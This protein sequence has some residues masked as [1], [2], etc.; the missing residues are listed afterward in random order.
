MVGHSTKACT[1]RKGIIIHGKIA[2]STWRYIKDDLPFLVDMLLGNL[3]SINMGI[4]QYV[5]SA[6]VIQNPLIERADEIRTTGSHGHANF[7]YRDASGAQNINITLK[8]KRAVYTARF[9]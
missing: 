2:N 1:E 5:G 9:V 8:T 3:G 7:L 4:D 6:V